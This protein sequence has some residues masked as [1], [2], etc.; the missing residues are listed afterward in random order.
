MRFKVFFKLFFILP[1]PA[2]G[3]T[4]L[5]HPDGSL[6]LFSKFGRVYCFVS[7]KLIIIF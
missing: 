1:F 5:K 3:P 2:H 4:S 7:P 6:T